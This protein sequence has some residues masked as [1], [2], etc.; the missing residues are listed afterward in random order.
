MDESRLARLETIV[1]EKDAHLEK[2][3][4]ELTVVEKESFEYGRKLKNNCTPLLTA[5]SKQ[6]IEE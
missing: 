2:L 5:D 3:K 6:E 4:A 1:K